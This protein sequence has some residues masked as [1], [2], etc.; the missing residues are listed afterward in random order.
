MKTRGIKRG[1]HLEGWFS[2]EDEK[3]EKYV[4]ETSWK[5][6]NNPKLVTFNWLKER[7]FMEVRSLL[8]EQ[9]LKGSLKCLGKSTQIW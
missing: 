4:H 2:G 8:K 9:M 1:G 3:I 5:M 7:K 6:I